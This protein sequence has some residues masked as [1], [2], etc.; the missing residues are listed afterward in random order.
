MKFAAAA[1][2]LVIGPQ[3]PAATD[4]V[5]GEIVSHPVYDPKRTRAKET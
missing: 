2:R 1:A 3:Q 4:T 5:A